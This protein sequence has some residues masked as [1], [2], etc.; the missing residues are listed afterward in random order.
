MTKLPRTLYEG[1]SFRPFKHE[2]NT[3]HGT[4]DIFTLPKAKTNKLKSTVTYRGPWNA[5]TEHIISENN[6]ITEGTYFNKTTLC[7]H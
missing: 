4:E 2:S 6:N 7:V 1:F 5:L 3:R